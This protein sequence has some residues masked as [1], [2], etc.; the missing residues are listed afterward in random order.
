MTEHRHQPIPPIRKSIHVRWPPDVAFRRFTKE[1]AT[2]WPMR[3]HSV[4]EEKTESVVF[5]D[6]V[7]GRVY[8][9][10]RGGEESTWGTIVHWEPPHRVVF[11]WHPGRSPEQAQEVELRFT[12]E[13]SGSRLELTHSKWERM[14]AVALKARR[15]YALGWEYV[16]R[17]GAGR[18][19]SPVVWG[20][21]ALTWTLRLLRKSRQSAVGSEQEIPPS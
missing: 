4:G 13:G 9:R 14:G 10:I 21:E 5:E 7:G 3:T 6:F 1:I 8:E 20:L 16:I 18:R 15:N 17:L 11:T 2:W 19:A 12:A